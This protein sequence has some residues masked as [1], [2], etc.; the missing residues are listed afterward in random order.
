LKIF[1]NLFLLRCVKM[2]VKTTSMKMFTDL[3]E[4]S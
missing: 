4:F 1:F 2:G 3:S